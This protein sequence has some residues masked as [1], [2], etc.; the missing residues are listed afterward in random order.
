MEKIKCVFCS[1]KSIN[2]EQILEVNEDYL[3]LLSLHPQTR[4]HLLV[5]PSVHFNNL[6]DISKNLLALLF[7]KAIEYGGILEKTLGA[8]A[9]MIKVNNKLY[10][11]EKSSGHVGHIHIHVIPRYNTEDKIVEIPEKAVLNDLQ[12]VKEKILKKISKH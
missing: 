7:N 8:R 5:V 1:L 6:R 3:I 11:L 4:G 2:K 10:E 9:Y 12:N